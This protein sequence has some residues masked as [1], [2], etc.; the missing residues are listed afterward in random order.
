MRNSRGCVEIGGTQPPGPVGGEALRRPSGGKANPGSG[1]GIPSHGD[2]GEW[3]RRL[4][5]AIPF[6]LPAAS[7]V[8]Q[9]FSGRL[10]PA[11]EAVESGG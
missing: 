4:Q 6:P 3:W 9:Q 7:K 2:V 1:M 5:A 11:E 10:L 8:L